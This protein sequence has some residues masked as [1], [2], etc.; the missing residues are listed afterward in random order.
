MDLISFSGTTWAKKQFL[1]LFTKS[2]N[3]NLIFWPSLPHVEVLGLATVA[4]FS[5]IGYACMVVACWT[6]KRQLPTIVFDIEIAR[7]SVEVRSTSS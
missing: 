4:D 6:S 5:I 7:T 2:G 1:R 3:V